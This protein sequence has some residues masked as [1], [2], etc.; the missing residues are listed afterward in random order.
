MDSLCQKANYFGLCMN[1]VHSQLTQEEEE[2]EFKANPF[3]RG[4]VDQNNIH[5]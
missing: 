1:S 3:P 4:H 5:T 2:S